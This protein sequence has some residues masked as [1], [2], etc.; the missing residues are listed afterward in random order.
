MEQ[1]VSEQM[2]SDYPNVVSG[3]LSQVNVTPGQVGVIDL[4]AQAKTIMF[5]IDVLAVDKELVLN[6]MIAG[7]VST[8]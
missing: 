3:A 1:N 5:R 6:A 4:D 2:A 8:A 7:F